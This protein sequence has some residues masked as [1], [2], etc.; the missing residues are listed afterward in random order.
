MLGCHETTS[1]EGVQKFYIDDITTQI[2]DVIL[3][4]WGKLPHGTTN[5]KHNL[6]PRQSVISMKFS[7]FFYGHY[8]MGKPAVA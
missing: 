4:F 8:F 3:F 7:S 1:E 2:W 5:Q 6:D